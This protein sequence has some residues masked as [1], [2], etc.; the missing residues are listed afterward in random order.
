[1][2]TLE[3]RRGRGW[4]SWEEVERGIFSESGHCEGGEW[5]RRRRLV[6]V[7]AR[8]MA[9]A[10]RRRAPPAAIPAIAGMES[11]VDD[12]DVDAAAGEAV[13]MGVTTEEATWIVVEAT[14]GGVPVAAAMDVPVRVYDVGIS[15]VESA[16]MVVGSEVL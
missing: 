3:G 8:K 13:G 16:L 15:D 6:Q 4:E 14:V 1:M 9:A 12:V 5:V 2:V 7:Y 11:W 10:M